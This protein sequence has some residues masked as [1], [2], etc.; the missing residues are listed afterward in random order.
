MTTIESL[1]SQLEELEKRIKAISNAQTLHQNLQALESY[2][3]AIK[4]YLEDV[5]DLLE[6]AN[7][8]HTDITTALTTLST[9]VSGLADRITALEN[10]ETEVDLSEIESA[11]SALETQLTNLKDGSNAT[12]ANLEGDISDLQTDLGSL[13]DRVD[14]AEDYISDI[15]TDIGTMQT[16]ITNLASAQ[17]S[18][19]SAQS[20]L[21]STVSGINTRLTAVE[22]NVNSLTG[23]IDLSALQNQLDEHDETCTWKQDHFKHTYDVYCKPNNT[24]LYVDSLKFSANM[25]MPIVLSIKLNYNVNST[26]NGT[27]MRVRI[28]HNNANTYVNNTVDLTEKPNGCTYTITYLV[29]NRFHEFKIWLQTSADLILNTIDVEVV[30]SGVMPYNCHRMIEA[31]CVNNKVVIIQNNADN[32]KYRIYDRSEVNNISLTTFTNQINKYDS[33]NQI[34]YPKISIEP[35]AYVSG[36]I[37]QEVEFGLIKASSDYSVTIEPLQTYSGSNTFFNKKTIGFTNPYEFSLAGTMYNEPYIFKILSTTSTSKLGFTTFSSPN[38]LS[39][40]SVGNMS[41][42]KYWLWCRPVENNNIAINSQVTSQES[43]LKVLGLF[44]DVYIYLIKGKSSNATKIGKGIFATGYVQ[45]DGSINVYVSDYFNTKKYKL[46]LNST[47]NEYEI[48][49]T[50]DYNDYCA[51]YELYDGRMLGQK[52]LGETSLFGTTY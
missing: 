49:S 48:S 21:T 39:T 5:E 2:F 7:S 44:K 45:T 32:I 28:K 50:T 10:A 29:Q 40:Y 6:D 27:T 51:L 26:S 15:N 25:Y 11:I 52:G 16:S 30:A 36:N 34:Y 31:K 22:T 12:I 13:E 3:D 24:D 33:T 43:E 4:D 37:V 35:Y 38:F 19:T 17:N 47:T 46:E 18:L 8:D 20:S 41:S 23:G 1:Q 14:D 42:S 9:T